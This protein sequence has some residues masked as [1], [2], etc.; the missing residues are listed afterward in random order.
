[1][2]AIGVERFP[3][4]WK[5]ESTLSG[6]H[7]AR[8]AS[9]NDNGAHY[10]LVF[11]AGLLIRDPQEQGSNRPGKLF[12]MISVGQ[13]VMFREFGV[14]NSYTMEGSLCGPTKGLHKDTHF[15]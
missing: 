6:R 12:Q 9:S 11:S 1:M 14:K 15:S 5:S 7:R 2:Y 8:K 10:G 4:P 3:G 13:A